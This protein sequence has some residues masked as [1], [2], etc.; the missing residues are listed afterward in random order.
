MRAI[1]RW[2]RRGSEEV[3][4]GLIVSTAVLILLLLRLG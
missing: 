2:G 1:L 4:K 3:E